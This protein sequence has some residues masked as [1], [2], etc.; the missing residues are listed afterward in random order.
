MRI[1]KLLLITCLL[2]TTCQSPVGEV[3]G[4]NSLLQQRENDAEKQVSLIGIFVWEV[5]E[6]LK[7]EARAEQVSASGEITTSRLIVK[8]LATNNIILQKEYDGFITSMY[9]RDLNSDQHP[10]LLL[11]WTRGTVADN[12]EVFS[13]NTTQAQ[14][15]LAETYRT[16]ATLTY[17]SGDSVDILISTGDSS[18]GPFYTT[19]YVWKGDRYKPAG[20][21]QYEKLT[22]AIEKLFNTSRLSRAYR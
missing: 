6:G 5:D 14:T 2:A 4:S 15:L 11:T 10:E 1:N 19:R 7:L 12:L 8:N 17:I 20:K 22:R 9:T 21:V 18:A 13:V 16:D 3:V